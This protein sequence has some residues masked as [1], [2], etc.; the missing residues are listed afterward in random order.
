[1]SPGGLLSTGTGAW[2]LPDNPDAGGCDVEDE[3]GDGDPVLGLP[4]VGDPTVLAFA[5]QAATVKTNGAASNDRRN[6][7]L[8]IRSLMSQPCKPHDESTMRA[9]RTGHG[10]VGV[11]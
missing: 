7:T 4:G 3:D 8:G 2:L 9:A 6:L 11:R 5:P 1:M 10:Q